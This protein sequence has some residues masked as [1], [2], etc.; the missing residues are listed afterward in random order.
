[1]NVTKVNDALSFPERAQRIVLRLQTVPKLWS[2]GCKAQREMEMY[3]YDRNPHQPQQ[4][5][6]LLIVFLGHPDLSPREL[7]DL[8]NGTCGH[9]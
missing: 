8:F 3:H 7:V 6:A 4:L 5:A 2:V 9:I 1:M